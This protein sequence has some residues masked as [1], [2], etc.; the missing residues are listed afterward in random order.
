[1]LIVIHGD[2]LASSRN[3]FSDQKQQ[4]PDA[5]LLEGENVAIT[6]LTQIFEGGGLF[7]EQKNVFIEQ[8]LTKK[9]R[10]TRATSKKPTELSQIVAYLEQNAQENNIVLW[11]GKDLERNALALFK[12]ATIRPFKLPQTLFL[13]LDSIK[14]GNG[15][16]LL[17][18]FHQTIATTEPEMVFFM[19]V[20]QIRLLLALSENS[21]E[22]IDEVK[23]LTWQKKKIEQQAKLF[24]KEH[25][26]ELY[27]KLFT[28][29]VGQKTGTLTGSLIT[30]IDFFLIEV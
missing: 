24:K 15:K 9:T 10:G 30:T 23:R 7:G 18:L 19:L 27:K 22:A 13:F 2:D 1:M 8:L 5:V 3:F 17:K 16:V 11:E 14:P 4:Y 20:R 25:L 29:E 28:I 6:E 12:A 21:N 26:Q